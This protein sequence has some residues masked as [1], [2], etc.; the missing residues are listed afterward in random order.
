MRMDLGWRLSDAD[1]FVPLLA[2][3]L[4]AGVADG[5]GRDAASGYGVASGGTREVR[6]PRRGPR[7]LLKQF[8]NHLYDD[9]TPNP[10]PSAGFGSRSRLQALVPS[11]ARAWGL[12]FLASSV[13]LLEL[14]GV[15]VLRIAFSFRPTTTSM[16][17]SDASSP[18]LARHPVNSSRSRR[19]P[20]PVTIRR[21]GR[22]TSTLPAR[23]A[24]PQRIVRY[25]CTWSARCVGPLPRSR[26]PMHGENRDPEKP[27]AQ[28]LLAGQTQFVG[29]AN[30]CDWNLHVA[31]G[32]GAY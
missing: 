10:R 3:V 11:W 1:S 19:P 20:V 14:R 23:K 31:H 8:T 13:R 18:P 6:G 5:D 32:V 27:E 17:T 9:M 2:G 24:K 7:S 30:V 12:G 28:P 26:R 21:S 4:A 16:P 15:V 25:D 22:F 29:T